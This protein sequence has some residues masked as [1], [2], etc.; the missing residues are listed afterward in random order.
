MSLLSPFAL[1]ELKSRNPVG[2]V[3]AQRVTLRR[4]GAHLIG[5]CPICSPDPTSR[6]A[7]RFEVVDNGRRWVCAVCED[8]GDVVELVMRAD[9]VG[10]LEAVGRLGGKP[11]EIDPGEAAEREAA[12]L[13]QLERDRER[14]VAKAARERAKA[15]AIW[16]AA[17]RGSH[18]IL[19]R[20]F[21]ARGLPADLIAPTLR[22]HED[23]EYWWLKPGDAPGKETPIVIHRGPAM[24]GII[25]SNEREFLGTHIT[26][27]AADGSGKAAICAPDG[28]AQPAKK[29]RGEHRGGA[30]HLGP[31]APVL[32]VGEGIETALS[33]LALLP[34]GQDGRPDLDGEAATAWSGVSLGNLSGRALAGTSRPHPKRARP[35][36]PGDTPD[37]ASPGLLPPAWPRKVVLLGDGDSDPWDTAARLIC[38]A[39]R[40]VN[41]GPLIATAMAP[42][43]EDFNDLLRRKRGL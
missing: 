2:D 14:Q 1:D 19:E 28:A 6:T 27:L 26:W 21:A 42:E 43:G 29:I 3:A 9:G 39:K 7:T 40:W 25:R 36:I 15:Q 17:A 4:H 5:P 30:I 8:G 18:P 13:G 10:F 31:P 11:A 12:R 24:L 23:L 37:P 22:L 16:D 20:Y 32:F 35:P 33:A 34:R 41:R 38:A